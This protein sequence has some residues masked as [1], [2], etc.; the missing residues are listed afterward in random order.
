MIT[1]F[2]RG[3]NVKRFMMAMGAVL[4]I[5]F[6]SDFIIHGVWLQPTY[7]ATASLWRT[8]TDMNDHFVWMI[9][10][11]LIFAKYFT[12]LFVKGYEGRGI[13]EGVRFGLVMG[14]FNISNCLVQYTVSPI[15]GSLVANW[16]VE[17]IAQS[18]LCAIV[19]TVVYK[20]CRRNGL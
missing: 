8:E 13:G 18:I 12:Y 5:F 17:G 7:K 1:E 20:K 15:P 10:A 2:M 4:V 11:H 14:I 19:A 9:L 3:I 16:A 6:V